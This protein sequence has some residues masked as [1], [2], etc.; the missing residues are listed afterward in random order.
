MPSAGDDGRQSF[1][2]EMQTGEM[3]RP[4]ER[5]GTGQERGGMQAECCWGGPY[6]LLRFGQVQQ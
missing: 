3:G 2:A 4:R 1:G 6:Q 5:T